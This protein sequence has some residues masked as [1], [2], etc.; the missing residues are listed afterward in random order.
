MALGAAADVAPADL[1][2]ARAGLGQRVDRQ[3]VLKSLADHLR[4]FAAD[5][6]GEGGVGRDDPPIGRQHRD[7]GRRGLE[8]P[9]VELLEPGGLVELAVEL[10]EELRVLDRQRRL[11]EQVA[12]QLQVLAGERRVVG[13]V[14]EQQQADRRAAH[15]ERSA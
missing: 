8:D 9:L 2:Q 1:D 11:V 7:A 5:Q 12:D 6:G 14:A 15:R 13:A 10:V 3:H 4:A